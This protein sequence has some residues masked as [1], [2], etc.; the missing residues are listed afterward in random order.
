MLS[1]S[2]PLAMRAALVAGTLLCSVPVM[3][4]PQVFLMDNGHLRVGLNSSDGRLVEFTDLKAGWNHI[5]EA[6]SPLS[7]WKIEALRDGRRT[8]LNPAKA[9]RFRLEPGRERHSARLT[10][11]GF[12]AE[13]GPHVQVTVEAGLEPNTS[14]CRWSIT[15]ENLHGLTLER[16]HFPQFPAIRP[17][18]DEY[19]AVPVW[20]GQLA[21]RP[22]SLLAGGAGRRSRVEWD[23]PGHTSMQCL[24][25]DSMQRPQPLQYSGSRN[26]V[27]QRHPFHNIQAD[28]VRGEQPWAFR[29]HTW[30]SG[31]R[32]RTADWQ[33]Q[34]ATGCFA[35]RY[36]I[37][38]QN[39][40]HHAIPAAQASPGDWQNIRAG[41]IGSFAG[42]NQGSRRLRANPVK[43]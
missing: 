36:P 24:A 13:V 40:F 17:Q 30:K 37:P 31:F 29:P 23:Y 10:W 2:G 42:A 43:A 4:E 15:V 19:L 5:A 11:S 20:M 16:L 39:P 32:R 18:E 8:E 26:G 6:A 34:C 35:D 22:R 41:T 12:Q 28:T 14:V 7:L 38:H 21:A 3:A 1:R 27:M 25:Q 9:E 33:R